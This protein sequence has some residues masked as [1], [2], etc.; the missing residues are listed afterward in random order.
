MEV[1]LSMTLQRLVTKL[2]MT[3]QKLK[4]VMIL[5]MNQQKYGSHDAHHD[6]T[7]VGCG[8]EGG[9]EGSFTHQAPL[10]CDRPLILLENRYLQ[11]F[12]WSFFFLFWLLPI[13]KPP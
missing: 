10:R 8:D 13:R 9:Q 12:F 7:E 3:Q 2:T 5:N 1:M 11:S 6:P 4:V